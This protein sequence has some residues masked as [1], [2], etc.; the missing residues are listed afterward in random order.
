MGTN[1]VPGTKDTCALISQNHA[2]IHHTN[3]GATV[4][5]RMAPVPSTATRYRSGMVSDANDNGGSPPLP[6]SY[7][8]IYDETDDASGGK[9]DQQAEQ[10]DEE[11]GVAADR[12]LGLPVSPCVWCATRLNLAR[13]SFRRRRHEEVR[14]GESY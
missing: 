9:G 7:D 11:D 14:D 13:C 12:V 6:L 8:V 1:N 2:T 10:D 4:L 5:V 3:A